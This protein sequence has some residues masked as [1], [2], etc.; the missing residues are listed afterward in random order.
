MVYFRD[1]MQI[2][3]SESTNMAPAPAFTSQIMST[4]NSMNLTTG[5]YSRRSK[6]FQPINL[7]EI[8]TGFE[9]NTEH[10]NAQNW[11]ESVEKKFT[12]IHDNWKHMKSKPI[13]TQEVG[14]I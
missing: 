3:P 14:F 2:S 8:S 4:N 7:P 11:Q 10:E 12:V 6:F 1:S 5:L 13:L 9:L